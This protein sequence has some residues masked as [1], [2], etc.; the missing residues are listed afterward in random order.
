MLIVLRPSL[1]RQHMPKII[2]PGRILLRI[3]AKVEAGFAFD[4]MHNLLFLRMSEGAFESGRAVAGVGE[5]DYQ[6]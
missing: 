3:A 2:R 6:R 4:D 5:R 1:G